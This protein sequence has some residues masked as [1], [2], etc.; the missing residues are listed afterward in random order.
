M[1]W[2]SP[3]SP[4][5]CC[6]VKQGTCKLS[7]TSVGLNIEDGVRGSFLKR[8]QERISRRGGSG[9][10]FPKRGVGE[11]FTKGDPRKVSEEGFGGKFPKCGRR[12]VSQLCRQVQKSGSHA[13]EFWLQPEA[14]DLGDNQLWLGQHFGNTT[15]LIPAYG[16]PG[17]CSLLRK[18]NNRYDTS[19]RCASDVG[20]SR[21]S[22]TE[23]HTPKR[24]AMGSFVSGTEC[25]T[26]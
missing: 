25:H 24:G 4:P 7:Q 17:G 3:W 10:T 13:C 1:L 21:M 2:A 18:R 22:P 11:N 15:I 6:Y 19:M 23:S 16:S 9:K 20:M 26:H 5:Q 14:K 12:E 8:G